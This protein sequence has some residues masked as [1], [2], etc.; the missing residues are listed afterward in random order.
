MF[1]CCLNYNFNHISHF[2]TLLQKLFWADIADF[3][4]L[5]VSIIFEQETIID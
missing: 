3:L 4:N 2:A 1:F 5:A